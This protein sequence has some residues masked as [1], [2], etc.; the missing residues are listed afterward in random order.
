MIRNTIHILSNVLMQ[1]LYKGKQIPIQF[2]SGHI[3]YHNSLL[4][5]RQRYN[6]QEFSATYTV[7]LN[8][9]RLSH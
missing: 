7:G 3:S 6:Y 5:L 1:V 4:T 9:P 8:P 2:P